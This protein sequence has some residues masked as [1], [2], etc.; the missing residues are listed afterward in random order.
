MNPIAPAYRL[1]GKVAIITGASRGIGKRL[2]DSFL[3]AGCAVTLVASNRQGLECAAQELRRGHRRVLAVACDVA[4]SQEVEAVVKATIQQFGGIDILVNNAAVLGPVGSVWETDAENWRRAVDVNLIGPYLCCRA[5]LPHM[6]AQRRGKIINLSGRGAAFPW[7]GFSAYGA[8]K[9]AVVRLTEGL[10][11]E[12][13][14]YN[15]QVNVMAPG[16]NDTDLFREAAA[17]EP[18]MRADLPADPMQPCRLALFLASEASN[19][20]TGKFIHVN[21]NWSEW[22][23]AD[24]IGDRFTLRRV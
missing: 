2:S 3:E 5:V 23:E 18:A 22:T 1:D 12:C 13:K 11:L 21:Q 15:I 20:I 14:L 7:P 8:S 24:L 10:A 19:H 9:A 6:I 4:N 16:A 17:H